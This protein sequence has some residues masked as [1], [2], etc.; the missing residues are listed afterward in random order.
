MGIGMQPFRECVSQ[1]GPSHVRSQQ[2]HPWVSEYIHAI[3]VAQLTFGFSLWRERTAESG[4]HAC[5]PSSIAD[6][7]YICS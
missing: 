5:K 7:F 2:G 3:Y 4:E 6:R 1:L